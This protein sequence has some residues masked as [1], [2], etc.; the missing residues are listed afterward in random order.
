[1][2]PLVPALAVVRWA[3]RVAPSTRERAVERREAEFR[4]IP[5]LNAAVRGVLALERIVMRLTSLP[6]GSSI[7]AVAAR[8]D[9]P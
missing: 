7:V 5:G 4:V 1:M 6:F 3:G 2:S 9:R 8:P